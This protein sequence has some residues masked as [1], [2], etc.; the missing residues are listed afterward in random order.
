MPDRVE[1]LCDAM[2]GGLA[3][4][5]R[6]AGYEARFDVHVRDGEL[7]RRALEE[8]ACLVTSDCGIMER[9]AVSEGLVRAV[10]V[11]LGLSP[12]EQ[13]AHVMGRL[14][15]C[16]REPRCMGCGGRLTRVPLARVADRVPPGA[17]QAYERFFRC[18]GCGKVFWRGTHWQSIRATLAR[19]V[20]A[21]QGDADHP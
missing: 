2:L 19:A 5:L 8:G 15:L 16:L 21:A 1:F 12:V 20:E 9:Y 18:A 11:P 3:R 10:F 7:V 14:G 17:R 4:W 13:L 6:A